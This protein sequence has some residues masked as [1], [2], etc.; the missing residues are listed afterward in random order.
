[1]E[2]PQGHRAPEGGSVLKTTGATQRPAVCSGAGKRALPHAA[3]ALQAGCVQ[4]HCMSVVWPRPQRGS[5]VW[6]RTDCREIERTRRW[7]R[8]ASANAWRWGSA[9]SKGK[10]QQ[11]QELRAW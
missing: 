7:G 8:E 9:K 10:A 11:Q 2:E 5:R 4:P 6:A 3:S 1:M